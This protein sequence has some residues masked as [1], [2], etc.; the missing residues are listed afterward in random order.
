M[1]TLDTD[2]L[3]LGS[4][5]AGL[6]AALHALEADA[7]LHVTIAVKGTSSDSS[8]VILYDAR[9]TS[10]SFKPGPISAF[11]PCCTMV[12]NSLCAGLLQP[13][14]RATSRHPKATNR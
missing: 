7:D 2:I 11:F 4:G 6:F 10:I 5:G 3:I 9:Y 13:A 12:M 1:K 14:N 8:A